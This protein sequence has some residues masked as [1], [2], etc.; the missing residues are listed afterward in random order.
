M[1]DPLAVGQR[2]VA[3]YMWKIGCAETAQFLPLTAILL[4]QEGQCSA[5]SAVPSG[6]ANSVGQPLRSVR[7]L[8]VDDQAD[9]RD[10]DSPGGHVG[11]DENPGVTASG[12]RR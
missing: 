2:P 1:I 4:T 3:V 8:E 7:Q 12:T 10:V 5:V 6:A 11:C 9:V